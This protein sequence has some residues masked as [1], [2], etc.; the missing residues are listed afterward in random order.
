MPQ[1]QDAAELLKSFEKGMLW[2]DKCLS[3]SETSPFSCRTLYEKWKISTIH[4]DSYCREIGATIAW[5]RWMLLSIEVCGRRANGPST[6]V[7]YALMTTRSCIFY[8]LQKV[9]QAKEQR[10]SSEPL[11][12][13]HLL[14]RQNGHW[15]NFSLKILSRMKPYQESST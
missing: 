5:M 10:P 13:R 12:L 1:T 2:E 3:D 4:L 11:K 15:N 7:I 14:Y 9:H 6:L 8:S